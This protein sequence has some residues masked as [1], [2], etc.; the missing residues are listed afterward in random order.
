MAVVL[1]HFEA[2]HQTQRVGPLQYGVAP[3][4]EKRMQPDSGYP[5]TWYAATAELPAR[6]PPFRGER[7]VEMAVIGG[8]LAGLTAALELARERKE[9]V[10]LEAERIGWGASGRNGGFVSAGFARSIGE[11]AD[12]VGTQKARELYALSREG[13]AYVRKEVGALAPETLTGEGW[14]LVY[15]RRNAEGAQRSLDRLRAITDAPRELWPIERTRSVLKSDRY[16]EALYDPEAFHIHPL[17]YCLALAAAIEAKEGVVHEGSRVRS[18]RADGRTRRIETAGGTLIADQVILA[19]SA[20]DRHLVGAIGRA[21]LPVATYA[22]VTARLGAKLEDAL[23]TPSA[24]SDDRR[25][26]DYYRIVDGDRLL[27]GGRI[28]TR[29]STP[30]RL[31]DKMRAD[32][33]STYPALGQ[34]AIDFCWPGQMAYALHK[35]PIIVRVDRGLWAM[36]AFGG[37]GINTTAMAGRLVARAITRRDDRFRLFSDF[38]PRWAGGPFG[39]AGVQMSYWGMQLR[40]RIDEAKAGRRRG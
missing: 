27:W 14:L 26:G 13:A 1:Y 17:G 10:L 16:F 33:V 23:G 12:I 37:H 21:V 19:T 30:A 15:R 25:A 28:T 8:G 36:T 40:D 29:R 6:R 32:M 9:V 5:S 34:P 39:Q 7:R 24:I 35:M 11:V 38:G 31:A 22:A 20:Y 3:A 2:N 18:I 4:E